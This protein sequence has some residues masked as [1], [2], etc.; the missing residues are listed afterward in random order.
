[1]PAIKDG[2]ILSGAAAVPS[3]GLTK[4]QDDEYSALQN[5]RGYAR[6]A[7]KRKG[8]QGMVTCAYSVLGIF[9]LKIDGD[10]YSPDKILVYLRDGSISLYDPTELMVLFEWLFDSTIPL[11]LQSPNLDWWDVTP[12]ALTGFVPCN[13]VSAPASSLSADLFIPGNAL[14]G[15]VASSTK[16][17]R[18][19][20][21]DQTNPGVPSLAT[22]EYGI[23]SAVTSYSSTQAFATGFGPVFQNAASLKNYRLNIGNGGVIQ[24]TQV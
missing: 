18:M 20:V 8:V 19:F 15:F 24:L 2:L 5:V 21:D 10:A 23:A 17:Y 14:F 4:T 6:F 12:A 11:Y 16:I 22:R 7:S 13:G 9:D 3:L 1:M